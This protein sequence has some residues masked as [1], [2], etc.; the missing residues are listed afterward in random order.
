MRLKKRGILISFRRVDGVEPKF[1]GPPVGLGSDMCGFMLGVLC[2]VA[3]YRQLLS[4]GA[5]PE[6]EILECAS[7][8][9][10]TASPRLPLL[11]GRVNRPVVR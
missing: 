5:T 3:V 7:G 4:E 1:E 9:G 8:I 10:V 11:E 2:E 6:M